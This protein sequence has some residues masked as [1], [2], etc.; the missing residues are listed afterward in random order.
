MIEYRTFFFLS[1]TDC[2]NNCVAEDFR[3]DLDPDFI[4]HI[5]PIQLVQTHFRNGELVLE[6]RFGNSKHGK[7]TKVILQSKVNIIQ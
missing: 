7:R 4:G 3:P 1:F 2:C 5:K 6:R